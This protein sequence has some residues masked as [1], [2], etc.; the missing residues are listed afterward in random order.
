MTPQQIFP[1]FSSSRFASLPLLFNLF[2]Y[3][4]FIQ[5]YIYQINIQEFARTT[6]GIY[7]ILLKIIS[8]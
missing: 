5:L 3:N 8:I 2:Y 1:M 4:Y 7:F 6:S